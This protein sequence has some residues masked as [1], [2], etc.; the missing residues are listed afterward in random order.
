M[1]GQHVFEATHRRILDWLARV[2]STECAW[3]IRTAYAIHCSTSR[4]CGSDALERGLSAKRYSSP[5]SLFVENW[6]IQGTSGY[7]FLNLCNSWLTYPEGLKELNQIYGD[8]THEPADFAEIAREK[9]LS[10]AQEALGSDVNRLASLF[11][12]ICENNRDRRD[13]TRA[14]IRRAI[15]EVGSSFTVYRTYVVPD[16]NEIVDEDYREVTGAVERAKSQRPI[17]MQVY[18]T[19]LEKYCSCALEVHSNPSLFTDF[20]NS[21]HR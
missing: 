19:L 4:A 5:E 17:S 12:E 11:V 2:F 1:S 3:T 9:K 7:D 20:S 8:F 15:R 18:S 21:L 13:Y 16:R 6:P 14:E 10:V